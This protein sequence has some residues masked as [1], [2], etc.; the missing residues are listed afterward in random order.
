MS[1]QGSAV[2]TTS[3]FWADVE[4]FE[5]KTGFSE[6]RREIGEEHSEA[7]GTVSLKGQNDFS[8]RFRSEQG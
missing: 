8:G 6:K 7:H 3:E 1:Q 5:V 4:V 2:T